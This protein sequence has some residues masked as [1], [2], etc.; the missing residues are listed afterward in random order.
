MI[1]RAFSILVSL[2]A[3]TLRVR[4]EGEIPS[5][6]IVVFW[7]SKMIAGWWVA[8]HHAVAIV[9]KSKDGSYLSE[10]LGRWNYRLVRG[11]SGKGGIEALDEA[12]EILRSKQA[13]RLVLT[14]DGPRGPKQVFKRGMFIAANELELPITFLGITYR[15]SIKL[16]SSWDNFEVPLPFTRTEI[17]I[18]QIPHE[19]LPSDPD[20]LS[21]FL[22]AR[23]RAF[24]E[25][26]R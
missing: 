19:A 25:V 17:T 26:S 13:D 7:H 14:P 16:S 1:A 5:R 9:S 3:R 10:I 15:R 2:L 22:L 23:S 11:S 24:Q 6:G 12:I 8:R 4:I 20:T 21:E 18:S